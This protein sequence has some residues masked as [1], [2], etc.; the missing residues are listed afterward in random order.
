MLP[1]EEEVGRRE[2]DRER[3]GRGRMAMERGADDRAPKRQREEG[4]EDVEGEAA[5]FVLEHFHTLYIVHTLD[6]ILSSCPHVHK[7]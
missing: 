7:T 6:H 2:V 5:R 4:A 3:M 1:E